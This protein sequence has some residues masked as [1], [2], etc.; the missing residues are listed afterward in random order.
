MGSGHFLVAALPMLARMRMHEEDL[1]AN[2]AV[3]RVI[4][5]N[6]HGLEID[7]RCTQI[8]AFALAMAAWTFDGASGYRELPE[9]NLACS[10]LAPEG[11]LEDWETLAGDDERL[12]NGMRRL[13]SIFQD[14]PTLGSLINPSTPE[15]RLDTATFSDLEPLLVEALSDG[16]DVEV[17]ERGV[18]AKGIA[19]AAEMLSEHYTLVSTN[20]PYLGRGNQSDDIKSFVNQNYPK[21]GNDLATVFIKRCMEI[22]RAGG[23]SCLVVPQKWLFLITYSDFRED[24]LNSGSWNFVARLG[25]SAFQTP[26]WDLNI[27]LF[28]VSSRSNQG[29]D[30]FVSFE[31]SNPDSITGKQESLKSSEV[32]RSTQ[33]QQLKNPDKR[34][35]LDELGDE[36]LLAQKAES[37]EG[38]TTG[39]LPRFTRK[40]WETKR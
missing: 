16:R 38:L 40:F 34:V 2:E 25:T 18:A 14:A 39:D 26:M 32:F 13:Y 31:A 19:R 33:R 30:S 8:A 21:S 27:M 11:D 36:P 37:H 24:V 28:S 10:G 7:E 29:G 4:A 1:S 17:R 22:S 35:I 6:L 9:M 15:N 3:D 12:Q 23:T 20:V 5:E